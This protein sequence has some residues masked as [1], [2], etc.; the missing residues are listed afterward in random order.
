MNDVAPEDFSWM[1]VKAILQRN[2]DLDVKVSRPLFVKVG[3]GEYALSD[4]YKAAS[5]SWDAEDMIDGWVSTLESYLQPPDFA[6]ARSLIL[7]Y[8]QSPH[9]GAFSIPFVNDLAI[10]FVCR[11][12][13]NRPVLDSWPSLWGVEA[14]ELDSIARANLKTYKSAN[15]TT[16]RYHLN[17]GRELTFR[18]QDGIA[19][20]HI[21]A[22]DL[23][24]QFRK[25]FGNQFYAA[26]PHF[27][28]LIAFSTSPKSHVDDMIQ[29]VRDEYRKASQ[30][31]SDRLFVVSRDG[32]AGTEP[33][34]TR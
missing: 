13:G 19:A 14:D 23:F 16:A 22:P 6:T 15:E 2:P 1:V 17:G 26:I 9:P 11:G 28:V 31:V 25:E 8:V 32:I 27:G 7:P 21:L 24:N 5:N 4:L 18:T 12:Q 29:V 3:N 20:S 33:L 10:H 34:P 30:K